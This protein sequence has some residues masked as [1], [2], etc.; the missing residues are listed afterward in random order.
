MI[1]RILIESITEIE[2]LEHVIVQ[3]LGLH[4]TTTPNGSFEM[5]IDYV[6][7]GGRGGRGFSSRGRGFH[8]RGRGRGFASGGRGAAPPVPGPCYRC[9]TLHWVVG[10]WRTPCPVNSVNSVNSGGVWSPPQGGGA[11]S[12][13][14]S[15]Q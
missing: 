5:D 2:Q 11:A 8:S 3:R 4:P 13:S 14:G 1:F 12:S 7:G 6:S 9:K 15:S 10:D